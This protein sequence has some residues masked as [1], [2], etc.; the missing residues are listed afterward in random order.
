MQNSK[1]LPV[2]GSRSCFGQNV[3]IT[4]AKEISNC[5]EVDVIAENIFQSI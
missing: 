3:I 5:Y 2:K 1:I 4:N